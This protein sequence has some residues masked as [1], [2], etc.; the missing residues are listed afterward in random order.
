MKSEKARFDSELDFILQK[1]SF[2]LHSLSSCG[3]S[4]VA[5]CVS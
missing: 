5:G 3:I 4:S 1:V 2:L